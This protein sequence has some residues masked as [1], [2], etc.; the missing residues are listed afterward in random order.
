MRG[1]F[2]E[3]KDEV[4]YSSTPKAWYVELIQSTFFW[5]DLVV[6]PINDSKQWISETLKNLKERVEEDC[7]KRFIYFIASRKKLRFSQK[8]KPKYSIFG[9]TLIVYLEEGKDKVEKKIKTKLIDPE[10][11][12]AMKLNIETTDR[13]IHFI[14]KNG[15]KISFSIHDF[16]ANIGINFNFESTIHYI[17][18]TKNPHIRPI[19]G[20]H[21]GLSQTLHNVSNEDNDFFIYYNLFKVLSQANNENYNINF[22]LA[23]SM[24]DEISVEDEG[25]L[26]EKSLIMY[27]KPDSQ[28]CN[29]KNEEQEFINM[30]EKFY[31]KIN[32]NSIQFYFEVQDTSD[33]F[34]FSSNKVQKNEK[35]IFTYLFQ[36]NELKL[37]KGTSSI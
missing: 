25:K 23:N 16:L 33:Y 7:E 5:Y 37:Y 3:F 1:I 11:G 31:S 20:I 32:I 13:T 15:S 9:S 21:R 30:F 35:H 14:E 12:K 36:N 28:N 4:I 27:F 19:D 22:V 10:T 2:G 6:N 26:L 18:Y 17:G 8:K 24:I 34:I 29:L